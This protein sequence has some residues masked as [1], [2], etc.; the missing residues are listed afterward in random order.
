MVGTYGRLTFG[1]ASGVGIRISDLNLE[2]FAAKLKTLRPSS[3]AP[4]R[5][6]SPEREKREERRDRP[7]GSAR[8]ARLLHNVN[9]RSGRQGHGVAHNRNFLTQRVKDHSPGWYGFN[10]RV[11]IFGPDNLHNRGRR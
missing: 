11:F 4:S 7:R 10:I 1:S 2:I 8:K 3:A 9:G 6:S 5:P